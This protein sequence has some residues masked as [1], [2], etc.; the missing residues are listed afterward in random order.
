MDYIWKFKD[1]EFNLRL[2]VSSLVKLEREIGKNP[3]MLFGSE[4]DALPT[5][6]ELAAVIHAAMPKAMTREV[7]YDL[8]DEWLDD[9]HRYDELFN[10]IT[11]IYYASGEW[12]E[13][14]EA[15]ERGELPPDLKRGVLSQDALY[16]LL[17]EA[18]Q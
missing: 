9:G 8:I 14:Y 3:L 1:K 4:G 11:E 12:M 5:T 2:R 18:K 6:D 10:L 13:D 16:E 7:V 15:D 17:E